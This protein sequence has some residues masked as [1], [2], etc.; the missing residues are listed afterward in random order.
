M[1]EPIIETTFERVQDHDDIVRA[2]LGLIEAA[3]NF[4]LAAGED[5]RDQDTER[6]IALMGML[7]VQA[8]IESGL[9]RITDPGFKLWEDELDAQT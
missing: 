6:A 8:G 9:L 3:L 7:T 5:V 1:E 4:T 2:M